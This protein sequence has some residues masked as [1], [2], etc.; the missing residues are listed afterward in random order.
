VR[1]DIDLLLVEKH[2][3]NVLDGL[4]GSLI[5]LVVDKTV[6]LG[7]TVFVLGNLAAE[8]V[9]K[10]GEG[11]VKSLV[12]DSDVEVLDE[13]VALASLAKGRVTL[14]PHDA[15][16][17]ALDQGIV[18]FLKS[19]LTI[20]GGVVV[21]VGVTEGA[22]SNSI[23]ADS[24]R[25]DGADLGEELEEHSLSDRGVEFADIERGRVLG[26]R[27]SRIRRGP[28]RIIRG[29]SAHIGINGWGLSIGTSI[30]GGVAEV[31]GE[32]I[33]SAGGRVCGHCVLG[34]FSFLFSR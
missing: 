5:G 15:A 2:A 34:V 31:V 21:D 12:V 6:A 13:N 30:E 26:V 9:T 3:I 1:A 8:N 17:T 29:A 4:L 33:N 10:S 14:G 11:V 32:L 24:N 25:S 7:V 18:E 27:S 16:R 19:L 23:T 28:G 20:R 22:S